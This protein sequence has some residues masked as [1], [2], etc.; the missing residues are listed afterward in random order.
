[1]ALS[2]QDQQWVRDMIESSA[3]AIM[4]EVQ[5]DRNGVILSHV[6]TCPNWIRL[7]GILFGIA[8]AMGV[9]SGSGGVWL[10]KQLGAF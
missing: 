5:D 4:R 10:A 3:Q 6:A 8:L 2:A 9:L 7:K 1:M